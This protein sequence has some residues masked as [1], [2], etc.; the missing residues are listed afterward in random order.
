VPLFSVIIPTYNRAE[1]L[2]EALATVFDQQFA[3]FEVL[4]VDDGSTDDTL[5]ILKAQSSPITV[6]RH[7]HQGPG[8]ARNA[9]VE[10]ATGEY[11]AFLDSDDVWFPWT[12]EA[13]AEV[14][15]RRNRPAYICGS[16]K[17]FEHRAEVAR[18]S[19]SEL[20][21]ESFANYFSTWPRQYVIGAGMIAVRR[22][23]FL[24]SGGFPVEPINLEDH[25]LSLKL[26]LSAGFVQ[27]V[28]PLTVGWR[29]HRGG[30]TRD[31]QKGARGC[32]ALI[33][34]ERAGDYPGGRQW[35]KVRQNIITTHTRSFSLESVRAGELRL[36]WRIYLDTLSWHLKLGRIRYLSMFPILAM[37]SA[38]RRPSAA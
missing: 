12:L 20:E 22:D 5:A 37:L 34:R 11:V 21:V 35:S 24:A 19:R 3:D 33:A 1:L 26:G 13:F 16:F 36:A 7:T 6:L 31:Q 25:D 27:I 4:V 38:F 2:Q 23:A 28:R 18:Q 14:I 29:L 8:A 30:V 32:A 10:R 17:Q 9:G 15:Q